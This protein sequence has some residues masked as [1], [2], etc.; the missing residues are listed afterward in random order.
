MVLP[1]DSSGV[2]DCLRQSEFNCD[3]DVTF[4]PEFGSLDDLIPVDTEPLPPL[5]DD[6]TLFDASTLP[7]A[8]ATLVLGTALP[9][10]STE[11]Y[12]LIEPVEDEVQ[13][14][15][16]EQPGPTNQNITFPPTVEPLTVSAI[17]KA[18]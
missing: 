14:T 12:N 13:D 7:N 1:C 15:V 10:A 5:P 8:F 17:S 4:D 9:L 16:N 6:K 18:R 3:I 11:P 2:S